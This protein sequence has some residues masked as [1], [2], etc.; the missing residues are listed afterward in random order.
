MFLSTT[1]VTFLYTFIL[2][3]ASNIIHL[4][5]TLGT[6]TMGWAIWDSIPGRKKRR[7]SSLKRPDR[8]RDYP[9]SCSLGTGSKEAKA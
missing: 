4:D 2:S 6:V 1:S 5:S 9:A 8:L 7:F 3:I